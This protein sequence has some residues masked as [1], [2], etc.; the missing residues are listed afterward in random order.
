M[1]A[2]R[3]DS[4]APTVSTL[5]TLANDSRERRFRIS[6][7]QDGDRYRLPAGVDARYATIALRAE[8]ARASAVRWFIDGK[9]TNARRMPL[10]AGTHVVRAS[11]PTAASDEV[12]VTIE[13]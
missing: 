11:T 10:V 5:T 4:A 6:S 9:P 12:H 13:R 8:G 2:A 7:P 1:L 3:G